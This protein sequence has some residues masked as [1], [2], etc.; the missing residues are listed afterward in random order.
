ME[1][2]VTE[3]YGKQLYIEVHIVPKD[4]EE[5]ELAISDNA[6]KHFEEQEAKENR[7]TTNTTK[8]AKGAKGAKGTKAAKAATKNVKP[9]K[10]RKTS[11]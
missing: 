5:D 6:K 8:T 3:R 2:D 10:R 11:D 1:R 4:G 7:K 9:P